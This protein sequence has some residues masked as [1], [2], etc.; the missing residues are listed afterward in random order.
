LDGALELQ[1][2]DT[3]VVDKVAGEIKA[4]KKGFSVVNVKLIDSE[5]ETGNTIIDVKETLNAVT[6]ISKVAIDDQAEDK[7]SVYTNS[8]GKSLTVEV[9][10]QNGDLLTKDTDYELSYRSNTPT[11]L[12][13]DQNGNLTPVSAGNASIT[14][15]AK[16]KYQDNRTISKNVSVVVKAEAKATSINVIPGSVKLV[17]NTTITQDLKVEVLDQYG[18][19]FT[20]ADA[21]PVKFSINRDG[22]VSGFVKGTDKEEQVVNGKVTLP[23]A[24]GTSSD[25]GSATIK[26]SYGSI[27][28]NVSVSL[29]KG[30]SFAGYVAVAGDTTLDLN[31]DVNDKKRKGPISTD[32]RVFSRDANGNYLEE[33]TSAVLK[34]SDAKGIVELGAGSADVVAKKVG[35]ENVY[36]TINDVR[37]ATVAFTVVKTSPVLTTV[38]QSNS[39]L[40]VGVNDGD[41][42]AKVIGST[43]NKNG[44]VFVAY[45]QYG[46][47]FNINDVDY[48]VISSNN[49]VV[50]ATD[51]KTLRVAGEGEATITLVVDSAKIYTVTIKVKA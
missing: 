2:S 13:V 3:T 18:D 12:V 34:F 24:A 10:D 42:T 33:V 9:K 47:K 16:D 50:D 45:D 1:S 29:V 8:T 7:L 5:L 49:N 20:P 21:T 15:F 46:E 51:K 26:V 37:I 30:G 19:L 27:T 6:T 44:G 11:L 31:P 17:V 32:I 39:S 25:A 35:T 23:L 28:K 43:A 40:N 36:V 14:V 48:T 38:S 41:I 4:L 22:I